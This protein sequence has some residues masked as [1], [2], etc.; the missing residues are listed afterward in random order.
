MALFLF[1]QLNQSFNI[2]LDCQNDGVIEDLHRRLT[3]VNAF[4]EVKSIL[5]ENVNILGLEHSTRL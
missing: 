2:D 4:M 1:L 5:K 3:I